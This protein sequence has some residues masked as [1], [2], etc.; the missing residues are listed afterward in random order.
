MREIKYCE[1]CGAKMITYRER[2]S[3]GLSVALF[4]FYSEIKKKGNKIHLQN[5]LELTKNEYNNFHKL[6]F[7]GL[8]KNYID[9]ETGYPVQGYWS[10][11]EKGKM[12]LINRLHIPLYVTTFRNKVVSESEENVSFAGI[13]GDDFEKYYDQRD[14]YILHSENVDFEQLKMF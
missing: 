14:D 6:K 2:I 9:Q 7:H 12:F 1:C 13:M 4:K 5:D 3:K 10:I 11:T 8:V